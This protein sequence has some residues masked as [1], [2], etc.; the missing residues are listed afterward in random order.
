MRRRD[1]NWT[2][3][4]WEGDCLSS[5]PRLQVAVATAPPVGV[6]CCLESGESTRVMM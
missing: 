1:Q 5:V 4:S 2:E 6:F 3:L